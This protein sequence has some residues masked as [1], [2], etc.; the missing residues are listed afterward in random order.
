MKPMLSIAALLACAAAGCTRVVRVQEPGPGQQSA[1]AELHNVSGQS[2]GVATLRQTPH[3]VLISAQLSNL[4]PGTHAF[5]IHAV[6]LCQ[7]P[8]TTAGP[9][10]NP[11]QRQHGMDNPAGMHQGDLPNLYVPESGS[12][13]IDVLVP[14]ASLTTGTSPILDAD[15]AALVIHAGA[16][17]YYTDPAGNAGSRIACGV[18]SR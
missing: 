16:D 14:D 9:H 18:I 8:F 5:H 15:G 2:V 7:P 3:G 11:L 1:R 12:A 6:G 17:D 10:L 4:P 13:R